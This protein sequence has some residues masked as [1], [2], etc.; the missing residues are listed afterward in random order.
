MFYEAHDIVLNLVRLPHPGGIRPGDPAE[1]VNGTD[2]T[3]RMSTDINHRRPYFVD[4]EMRISR[5]TILKISQLYGPGPDVEL[6]TSLPHLKAPWSLTKKKTKFSRNTGGNQAR[7][8]LHNTR[9]L[10]ILPWQY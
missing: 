4:P 9:Q 6:H 7:S 2:V 3:N 8:Y 10:Q 5:R 1:N